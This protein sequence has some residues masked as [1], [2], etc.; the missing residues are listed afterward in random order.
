MTKHDFEAIARIFKE[1][2]ERP[3]DAI[4]LLT[5][6][7]KLVEYLAARYPNFNRERF[8]KVARA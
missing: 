4:S 8:L 7:N 2:W 5:V 1:E 6:E 3:P